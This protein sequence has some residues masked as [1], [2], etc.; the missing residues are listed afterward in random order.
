MPRLDRE[1]LMAVISLKR[2]PWDWLFS[3]RSLPAKST[4]HRVATGP[5][6]ERQNHIY[7]KK[8]N[9]HFLDTEIK[10]TNKCLVKWQQNEKK[11]WPAMQNSHLHLTSLPTFVP[12][13][14]SWKTECER[15]ERSFW[16]VWAVERLL[17]AKAI[18]PRTYQEEGSQG[19]SRSQ[20]NLWNDIIE[21]C[22]S[23]VLDLN[24]V[25]DPRCRPSRRWGLWWSPRCWTT[26]GSRAP[27]SCWLSQ[28]RAG[29]AG[30]R[31]KSPQSSPWSRTEETKMNTEG[32]VTRCSLTG[33]LQSSIGLF[34]CGQTCFE[35]EKWYWIKQMFGYHG[36]I[37]SQQYNGEA[38][39]PR[40]H[41]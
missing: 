39:T 11:V 22:C 26:F 36:K 40:Q 25:P 18:R 24:I 15:E 10:Q 31:C 23:A 3:M 34:Q 13:I 30:S 17:L 4:K 32:N 20:R 14:S 7:M 12:S 38:E 41:K 1:P 16:A 33:D 5:R 9:Q 27:V 2:S 37:D 35:D 8:Q 28:C 6:G 21:R 29:H 19:L